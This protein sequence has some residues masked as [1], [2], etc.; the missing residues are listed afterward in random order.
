[1]D[2]VLTNADTCY[3][4]AENIYAIK[5]MKENYS[6]EI[7]T[8]IDSNWNEGLNLLAYQCKMKFY[9]IKNQN[10]V[11][12]F[13]DTTNG[14]YKSNRSGDAREFYTTSK[15]PVDISGYTKGYV[16]AYAKSGYGT[17]KAKFGLSKYS[18]SYANS[19]D[20]SGYDMW[21]GVNIHDRE[22]GAKTNSTCQITGS[23]DG[24]VSTGQTFD[25][26]NPSHVYP[27]IGL[28]LSPENSYEQDGQAYIIDLALMP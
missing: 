18:Y 23:G 3:A 20:I 2:E 11:N 12:G 4:L 14:M 10:G 13:H 28:Q 16:T 6:S 27:F 17:G 25:I 19:Q 22:N 26:T 24:S 1:L 21:Y 9:I 8:A 5:I 7:T 15:M